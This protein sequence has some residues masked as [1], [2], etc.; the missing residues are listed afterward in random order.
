MVDFNC[1]GKIFRQAFDNADLSS[2]PG[3]LPRFP[4]GCCAWAARMI[5]HFLKYECKLQP[6]HVCASSASAPGREGGHEWIEINDTIIDITSDQFPRQSQKVIVSKN[7][8]WHQEWQ[9]NTREGIHPI[10]DF[11]RIFKIKPSQIYEDI[12][13]NVRKICGT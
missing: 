4:D 11:D 7:S 10:T 9:V 5:G 13:G 2:A 1:V 6:I 8:S 12:V 3:F